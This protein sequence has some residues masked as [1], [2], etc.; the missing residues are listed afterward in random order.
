MLLTLVEV[1][2]RVSLSL[3][4]S[5]SA[6]IFTKYLFIKVLKAFSSVIKTSFSLSISLLEFRPL[7]LKHGLIIFQNFLLSVF[8]SNSFQ[9]FEE[10]LHRSFFVF[11][12][13]PN[14]QLLL[15]LNLNIFF[16]IGA[17]LW[18]ISI[19]TF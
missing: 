8:E 1:S 11:Y 12:S 10:D 6:V 2:E 3:L 18:R 4:K 14:L 16:F 15:S 7:L 9:Y 5:K 17:C 19:K 13:C